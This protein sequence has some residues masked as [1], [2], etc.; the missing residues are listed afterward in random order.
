MSRAM[1]VA[2]ELVRLSLAGEEASPLT[3]LQLHKLLYYV[4]SWSLI[5]RQSELFPENLEAWRYGPVV[6]EVYRA[7]PQDQGTDRISP[8]LFANTADLLPEEAEFVSQVW[9]SYK[10]YSA[11]ELFKMTH[12]ETPWIKAWGGRPKDGHGEDPISVIEIEA[13]FAKQSIPAPLAEYEHTRRLQEEK[14]EKWL[15]EMPPLDVDRLTAISK[16]H[17]PSVKC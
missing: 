8:A 6:P 2:K 13:Y 3:N 7:L 4:Q 5:V 16:S 14:A 1:S 15:A 17:S 9:E 12:A 10:Q 11:I